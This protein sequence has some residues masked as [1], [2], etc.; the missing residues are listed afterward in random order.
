MDQLPVIHLY[1]HPLSD[2]ILRGRDNNDKVILS[3]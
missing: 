3:Y 1:S 2:V